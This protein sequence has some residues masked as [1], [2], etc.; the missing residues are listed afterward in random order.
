MLVLP[1]TSLVS[2]SHA[3]YRP[4]IFSSPPLIIF[5]AS[6]KMRMA[7]YSKKKQSNLVLTEVLVN[8]NKFLT[9][10]A[11]HTRRNRV[12]E[13]LSSPGSR[14]WGQGT[15]TGCSPYFP[16][17]DS[18]IHRLKSIRTSAWSFFDGAHLLAGRAT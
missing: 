12:L 18:G 13:L 15:L 10:V 7:T 2:S 6:V 1:R 9:D 14:L 8:K 16:F 3:L 17:A 5:L 11:S 4:V